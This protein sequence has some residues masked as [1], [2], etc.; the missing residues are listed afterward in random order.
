MN[1]ANIGDLIS[2]LEK[3]GYINQIT[4]YELLK[5][6][7]NLMCYVGFDCTAQSLHIG[8][9]IQIMLIRILNRFGCKVIILLGGGTTK[10]GDPSGKDKTR[11]II[12][13][14]KIQQNMEGV[15]S[16]LLQISDLSDV[17]FVN[18]DEWLD[19]INYVDFLNKVGR[20]FSINNMLNFEFIKSRLNREQHLSFVE[21]NYML[22]QAYDFAELCERYNC[23]LQFGG[24]DQW[25][26]IVSGV[27]LCRKLGLGTVFGITTHLIT[28]SNGLKMGKTADGA[29]WLDQKNYYNF[30]N[31]FRN[32]HDD[33]VFKFMRLFTDLPSNE[34]A[35]ME[36]Q[37]NSADQINEAKKI[38]ATRAS[39]I[40][41]GDQLANQ[42]LD[43]ATR[44]FEQGD[45]SMLPK[46]LCPPETRIMDFIVI[47]KLAN[48][49]SEAKKL[50]RSGAV[51]V[52]DQAI[53]SIDFIVKNDSKVSIGK[54]RFIAQEEL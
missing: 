42:A 38:L 8:S 2:F 5:R 51:K 16:V 14:D 53:L 30:W 27:D 19:K 44:E 36:N 33:D 54:K 24:S 17:I 37:I 3:R 25:G 10:I 40:V 45:G 21:F 6:Q 28:T 1:N 9:L 4:N 46:L 32:A 48:S 31:Y 22:L 41:Y 11:P 43:M 7:S 23:R 26:N 47:S 12:T 18:N 20:H 50:I 29:V 49:N 13:E 35:E 39:A 52:D 15:K 34:I